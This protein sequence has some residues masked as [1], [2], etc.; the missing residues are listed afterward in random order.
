[1]AA[2]ASADLG[3]G[4]WTH[5]LARVAIRPL[6]GTRVTPNHLTTLRLATGACRDLAVLFIDSCRA[7]GLPARFVSG[8]HC[9]QAPANRRYLHAWAEV[10]LPGAGWRGFDPLQGIAVADQH[11]AVA[12]SA[13]PRAAAPISGSLNSAATAAHLEVD[14]RI[15]RAPLAASA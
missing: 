12:A 8:Y 2:T 1:M 4:S 15:D 14:L 10:F 11:I 7:V 9:G 6:L 13:H 5:R 3:H